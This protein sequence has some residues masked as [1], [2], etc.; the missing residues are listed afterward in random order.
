MV[1]WKSFLQKPSF[2]CAQFSV[3]QFNI[4]V[5]NIHTENFILEAKQ[6]LFNKVLPRAKVSDAV[7]F[8]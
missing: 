8:A 1:H 4:L 7:K 5:L 3:F 2:T 6:Q